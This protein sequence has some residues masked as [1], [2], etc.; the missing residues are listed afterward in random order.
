MVDVDKGKMSLRSHRK[1]KHVINA[2]V[3]QDSITKSKATIYTEERYNYSHAQAVEQC[4]AVCGWQF[5]A[6]VECVSIKVCWRILKQLNQLL[7]VMLMEFM[8]LGT[9]TFIRG[10]DHNA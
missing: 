9:M 5:I 7:I 1:D 8:K 6:I 3:L 10:R 2:R 4:Y